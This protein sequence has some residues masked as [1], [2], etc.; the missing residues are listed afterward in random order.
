MTINVKHAANALGWALLSLLCLHL[1]NDDQVVELG[2][3]PMG[4][5]VAGMCWVVALAGLLSSH[6]TTATDDLPDEWEALLQR[7]QSPRRRF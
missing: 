7:A 1:A 2:G 4:M 5:F 6:K 3:M